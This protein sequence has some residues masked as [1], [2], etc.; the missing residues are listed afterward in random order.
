MSITYTRIL[1]ELRATP[2]LQIADVDGT[3]WATNSFWMARLPTDG[4]PSVISEVLGLYNLEPKP[5]AY[6][7]GKRSIQPD[8]TANYT[9]DRIA[10]LVEEYTKAA[11]HTVTPLTYGD[12]PLA[13]WDIVAKWLFVL[14]RDDDART[15]VSR[16][17]WLLLRLMLPSH[18]V[19]WTQGEKH[20]APLVAHHDGELVAMLM[21][22]RHDAAKP[23]R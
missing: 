19:T 17:R 12:Y 11:A 22:V 7:C 13:L 9:P 3:P 10:E 20:L 16:E 21:P 6:A 2:P 14:Q 1:K 23:A 15:L 5:G 4:A 18:D 8:P